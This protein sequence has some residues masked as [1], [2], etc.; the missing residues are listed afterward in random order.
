MS[1]KLKV[2]A[3]GFSAG[4]VKLLEVFS[5]SNFI[6]EFYLS[7]SSIK[8]DK[9]LK[10]FKNLNIKSYLRENWKNVN[11]FIFIGSLG[12]TTRLISSLISNKESDPGVIVTD[13]KGSK[14]IP[15]LNLHH[16]KTKN[17]ALKIQ[18][19][20]GGEIIE[21]NNSSLENLLNLDSFGNNWGWRRSGSI[22][23]WSKLVINQSK[24][25]TIFFQQFSGNELWKGCK[26]SRNLN[27]L[28][29]CDDISDQESTFFVGINKQY[30]TA[31]HPPTLWLGIGCER[32][33]NKNFIQE[34]LN[35]LLDENDI[36][37]LS[38]AGIATVDLKKDEQAILDIAQ[39]NQWPIKFITAKK[40]LT[41]KV[42]NPSQ[43]VFD[44][45]GSYSVAEASCLNA[46]GQD[47][48]LLVEKHI[49]INKNLSGDKVGA[50]TLSLAESKKQ[51][52]P[53]RGQI[54]VIGSGPGD[55][56]L[57]T[58]DAKIALSEC[59]VWIGYKMYLDLLDPLLREDQIRI[60][61]EIK[62]EK[63][64]CEKAINLAQEGIKVALISSGDSSIYGMAG[65][66]LEL[67]QKLDKKVRPP[68]TI[69]PGISCIQMAA[70]LAG[71][72]LMND[73]CAISLSDKLTPWDIIEK[74]I[75]GALL[76]DFVVAIFNPQSKERNWQLNKT[77]K[78]FLKKRKK[79]TP[80]IIARQVGRKDQ[81][82]SFC[83][84]ENFP[85]DQIDMLTLI[86]IGNSKTKLVDNKFISPRGYL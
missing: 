59:P 64:R 25:E 28:D 15:I 19:F 50:V 82:I 65:L 17:I 6:D 31:W 51:F 52:A 48:K 12:A 54:H 72:P 44:E 61:S 10:G 47:A 67:I 21:T 32:N 29:Y 42:P 38:I 18:N 26:P 77:I 56:S 13:K 58:V 8:E 4:S 14:I 39:E 23:N 43:A 73:F 7:S 11:V 36:S 75:K 85:S 55:L 86:I 69:H 78:M 74:R 45:I 40:L 34:S 71:S 83:T 27:Q 68:F 41:E 66:L 9:N 5:R 81:K 63:K 22:E 84:L 16:N 30:R 62:E 49:F 20:I 3:I 37:E 80:T 79:N 33:T 57:L 70:S 24:K 35:Q 53:S 2:I 46:A 60:D 76:G 1:E